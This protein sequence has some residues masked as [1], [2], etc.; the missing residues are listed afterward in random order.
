MFKEEKKAE[1]KEVA[2][3]RPFS[4]LHHMER[5]FDRFFGEMTARPWFGLRWP[6]FLRL[7]KELEP[8]VPVIEVY[9]E[10]DDLVVKAELPGMEKENLDVKISEGVLTIRGER[11]EEEET[12]EKG[13][14][15]SERY[16][17]AFTRSIDIPRDLETEKATAKFKKGVLELRIPKTE[18]AK[19]TRKVAIE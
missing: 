14:Y 7:R 17:G 4:Q 13:N 3:F 12:R 5:E 10:K 18:E 16:Y 8:Q 15:Y 6:D 11:K 19:K 2:H 9:E 1:K